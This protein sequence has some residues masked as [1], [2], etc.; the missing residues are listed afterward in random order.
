MAARQ[1][2]TVCTLVPWPTSPKWQTGVT[3]NECLSG[4]ENLSADGGGERARGQTSHG[5]DVRGANV[6]YLH[7][8][9][10]VDRG[11]KTSDTGSS[12]GG[13]AAWCRRHVDW[14]TTTP[15]IL[16]IR[17]CAHLF[18]GHHLPGNFSIAANRCSPA[19]WISRL[20]LSRSDIRR[21]SRRVEKNAND[22]V[23]I[24][25]R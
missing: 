3:R 6:L 5:A 17:R 2:F 16:F 9:N 8:A 15:V 14:N 25:V 10:T 23:F 11:V 13:N 18:I 4:N 7:A 24:S 19:D 1:N 20:R 12:F 22:P 21:S